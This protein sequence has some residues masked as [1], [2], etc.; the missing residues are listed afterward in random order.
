M[1]RIS[2]RHEHD[3]HY[4]V[5]VRHHGLTIDSR[6]GGGGADLGPTPTELFVASIAAC[7]ASNVGRYLRR[8]GYEGDVRVDCDYEIG[9][10]RPWRV[11][12]VTLDVLLPATL[13]EAHHDGVR[14]IAEHCTVENSLREAPEIRMVLRDSL[15]SA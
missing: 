9:H 8:E 4:H 6:V 15:R 3:D 1:A 11:A 12:N 10:E 7:V 2:V 5:Q 14:R 13:D